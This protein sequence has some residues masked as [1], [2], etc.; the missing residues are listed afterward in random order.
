MPVSMRL[1]TDFFKIEYVES[2][3]DSSVLWESHCHARFEMIGVLEGDVN[4]MIEGSVYRLTENQAIFIPPLC[5]HTLTANRQER[6]RRITVLFDGDAIPAPMT[7]R[8]LP[9][10]RITVFSASRLEKLREICILDNAALYAPLADSFMVQSLYEWIEAKTIPDTPTADDLLQPTVRYIDDHLRE[11]IY[12]DDLARL[13]SR[14]RSSFCHLFEERM[15]ITPKQYILQ[16]KLALANKMILE[17]F[18]PTDVAE[19]LGYE[20]YSSFYRMYVKKYGVMP[21]KTSSFYPKRN[22]PF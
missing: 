11:K 5:Y 7:S 16:K 17:G 10:P 22:R 21:R 3:V 8:C 15:G 14:S 12:I 4:V 2:N 20:N 9:T 1:D 6:Y 13:T 19:Q 18:T